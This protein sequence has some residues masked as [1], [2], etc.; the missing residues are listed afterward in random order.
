MTKP[1]TSILIFFIASACNVEVAHQI[2]TEDAGADTGDVEFRVSLIDYTEIAGG[3]M[4][5]PV[6]GGV[7][8]RD[9]CTPG[10]TPAQCNAV[11][12]PPGLGITDWYLA[13]CTRCGDGFSLAGASAWASY[14]AGF[15]YECFGQ[16]RDADSNY[17]LI[18]QTTAF[19]AGDF[20]WEDSMSPVEAACPA[21][22]TSTC[23]GSATK[24]QAHIFDT[25]EASTDWWDEGDEG[26]MC[27]KSNGSS[28][29]PL[30]TSGG[31][32][33]GASSLGYT[34]KLVCNQCNTGCQ[35]WDLVRDGAG[36]SQT[37]E[38][39]DSL[40]CGKVVSGNLVPMRFQCDGELW[41]PTLS[42]SASIVLPCPASSA[43]CV[44]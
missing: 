23:K 11:A 8:Q 44:D 32:P 20:C 26:M 3:E 22:T 12:I 19:N 10:T 41:D 1:F 14:G 33:S 37:Q 2:D 7:Q 13:D 30:N 25:E 27:C 38:Q 42:G 5:C 36:V 16:L 15:G 4:C 18:S 6:I 40:Q 28:C 29:I 31:C 35:G 34:K 9:F 21:G 17:P 39:I 43:S 24:C